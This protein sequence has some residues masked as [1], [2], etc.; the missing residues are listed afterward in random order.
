MMKSVSNRNSNSSNDAYQLGARPEILARYPISYSVL[1]T[2]QG[3]DWLEVTL[4][5]SVPD[6]TLHD[7]SQNREASFLLI[8]V[9]EQLIQNL[10][11][12]GKFDLEMP[13][14][15]YS[16]TGAKPAAALTL[17]LI[18]TG[19]APSLLTGIRRELNSL[20]VALQ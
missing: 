14:F 2:Q 4:Q 5:M 8:G 1:P 15:Y 18:F 7:H 6:S 12:E 11:P 10:R 9:A 17:S 13:P 3:S 19:H 20:G 16:L